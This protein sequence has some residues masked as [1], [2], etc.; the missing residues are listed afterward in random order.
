[1][2][3]FKRYPLREIAKRRGVLP[4]ERGDRPRDHIYASELGA[5]ARAVWYNWHF[6]DMRPDDDFSEF[7]GALGHGI[8]EV[9][10][11]QI[12]SVVVSREVSFYDEVAHIS[13][14]VD[15]VI[16]VT[17]D[18]EMI[19][20]ELKTTKAYG[21]FLEEPLDSHL[22]QLRY[23]LTQM[24]KAPFGLLVYY[25]LEGWGDTMGHWEALQIPRDD[26]SVFERAKHLH[27]LIAE[28]RPPACEK[29]NEEDGCWDCSHSAEKL[30]TGREGA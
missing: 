12:A 24:P 6:P 17:H 20:V 11:K 21:R 16:R 1:M 23:Y 18:G 27:R 7:R 3:M 30:V 4:F 15:F 14:R 26:P 29:M 5:C 25:S 8:E 28:A 10:A 9:V 22:L 13:G 19:P 2:F